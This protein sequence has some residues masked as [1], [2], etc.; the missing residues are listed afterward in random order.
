MSQNDLLVKA[1]AAG[2]KRQRVLTL[3][4]FFPAAIALKVKCGQ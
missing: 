4:L 3:C 2:G 1:I